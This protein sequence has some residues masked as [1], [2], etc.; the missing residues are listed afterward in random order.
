M[1]AKRKLFDKNSESYLK[2]SCKGG[3]IPRE[4][5]SKY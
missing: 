5:H 4:N 3:Y 2:N 1:I